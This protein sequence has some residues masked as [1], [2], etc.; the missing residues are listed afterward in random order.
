MI[1]S[2]TQIQITSTAICFDD[3][4]VYVDNRYST[5]I[6][7]ICATSFF[8]MCSIR[9]CLSTSYRLQLKTI[10]AHLRSHPF[11][12]QPDVYSY[13]TRSL[14][15]NMKT[16]NYIIGFKFSEHSFHTMHPRFAKVS[17]WVHYKTN[18]R[19]L[20]ANVSSLASY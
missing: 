3:S 17:R 8:F 13:V 20:A 15:M 1:Q 9:N 10:L 7:S 14:Y 19:Q 16:S 11:T 5:Y 18:S 2:I 6:N 4:I 12:L